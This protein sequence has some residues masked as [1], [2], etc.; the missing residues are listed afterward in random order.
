MNLV[1]IHIKIKGSIFIL[2]TPAEIV[3]NLKGRGVRAATPT[4]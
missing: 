1:G 3:N 4:A 2:P